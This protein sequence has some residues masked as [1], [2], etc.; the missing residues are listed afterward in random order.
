MTD[1]MAALFAALKRQRSD[2]FF[3][4]LTTGSAQ[5]V[6]NAMR[7]SGIEPTDY[8]VRNVQPYEVPSFL[9]ASDVGIAFYRPGISRLGTSPVKVSE[10]LSCG[11]P[12]IVNAGI[13]DSDRVIEQAEVGALVRDF[14]D[15]E[16]A[17]AAA[18][19]FRLVDRPEQTRSYA[20]EVAE[21]LFDLRGPGIER[22]ARLYEA[23]L[24]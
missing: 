4:W 22:Y 14:N 20:R 10:Y 7:K 11:L 23:L 6:E 5:T 13:G 21:R 15:D 3:L 16:Y 18:T 19:V 17:K 12:V 1:E 24:N 9:S 8:A 2:A